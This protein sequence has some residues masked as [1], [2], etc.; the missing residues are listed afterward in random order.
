[1]AT[2]TAYLPVPLHPATPPLS[3]GRTRTIKQYLSLHGIDGLTAIVE[4]TTLPAATQAHVQL[5]VHKCTHVQLKRLQAPADSSQVPAASPA[6]YHWWQVP[7]GHT[8]TCLR[9]QV[10]QHHLLE[11][12]NH[13]SSIGILQHST[14]QHKSKAGRRQ[15]AGTWKGAWCRQAYC[16]TASGSQAAR[17]KRGLGK[18]GPHLQHMLEAGICC[19][20]WRNARTRHAGMP[21]YYKYCRLVGGDPATLPAGVLLSPRAVCCLLSLND[22]CVNSPV[23]LGHW[24]R[25]ASSCNEPAM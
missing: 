7:S 23:S 20:S 24:V 14:V 16:Q 25:F 1:M 4:S 2:A 3:A 5:F 15:G 11:P 6:Q 18:P 17:P 12:G 10:L 21:Y 8:T 19:L 22:L 13:T 9:P